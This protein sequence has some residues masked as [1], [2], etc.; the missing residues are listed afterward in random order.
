MNKVFKAGL[1]KKTYTHTKTQ[2]NQAVN[3]H[4]EKKNTETLLIII[5][6]INHKKTVVFFL[7]KVLLF[8]S[9]KSA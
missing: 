9:T 5:I 8:F 2:P 1:K 4:L 6:I 3:V 7:S